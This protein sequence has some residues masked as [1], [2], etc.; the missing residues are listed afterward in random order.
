VNNSRDEANEPIHHLYIACR[1]AYIKQEQFDG[2][3]A[4]YE[5][6]IRMLNGLERSFEQS[7]PER[8]RKWS[9]EPSEA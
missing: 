1:K 9:V 2:L 4:R 5:E 7:L 6:C 3:S 8:E